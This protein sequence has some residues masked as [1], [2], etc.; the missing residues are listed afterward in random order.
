MVR[1][2]DLRYSK[3]VFYHRCGH[4]ANESAC[5]Y[6][7]RGVGGDVGVK[8]TAFFDDR[9]IYAACK[10][11]DLCSV[12]NESLRYA[13][14]LNSEVADGGIIYHSKQTRK[15]CVVIFYLEIFDGV[16]VTVKRSSEEVWRLRRP[17]G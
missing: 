9:V 12:G 14:A 10:R 2:A 17:I 6:D 5:G 8:H 1:A 7:S 4:Q 13:C 15:A 16:E 3:A 11:A